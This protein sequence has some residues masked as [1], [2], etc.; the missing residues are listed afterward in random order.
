MAL[1]VA[2]KLNYNSYLNSLYE[3]STYCSRSLLTI[4]NYGQNTSPTLLPAHA[5]A[6]R[7][8]LDQNKDKN[9]LPE[10]VM[11]KKDLAG[12]RKD[13][14]KG[15]TPY[16]L[17]ADSNSDGVMDFAILLSHA[18]RPKF[19]EPEI[20]FRCLRVRRGLLHATPVGKDMFLNTGKNHRLDFFLNL[21]VLIR[22]QT[23]SQF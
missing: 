11:P 23:P 18:G 14:R 17:A 3:D 22:D 4:S 15:I 19:S 5:D 9:F 6:L 20:V 10:F 12:M 1:G 13:I 2:H 21:V 16:Y 8:Y 7:K